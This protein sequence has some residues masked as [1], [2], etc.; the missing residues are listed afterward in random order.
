MTNIKIMQKPKHASSKRILAL[1][2]FEFPDIS[3]S[4]L[5]KK[6]TL[7]DVIN[8]KSKPFSNI[9]ENSIGE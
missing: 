4:I 2:L 1:N 5:N 7:K 3:S 8:D 6:Y 9:K